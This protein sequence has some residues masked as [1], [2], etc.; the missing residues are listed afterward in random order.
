MP[1]QKNARVLNRCGAR[2]LR[3]QELE[4]IAGSAGHVPTRLTDRLTNPTT[5]PDHLFDE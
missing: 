2:E 1:N 3:A 4:E 5:N